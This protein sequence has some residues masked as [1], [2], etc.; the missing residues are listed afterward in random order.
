MNAEIISIGTE[1]LLGHVVD[2]NSSFLSCKLS[3]LGIDVYHHTTVGDNPAR[4]VE[5]IRKALGRADIVLMTG[6]LGPTVDDVTV[7][8]V[9]NLFGKS[10]VRPICNK[11]GSAPGIVAEYDNKVIVCLP[12]PPREAIPM[13]ENDIKPYI[14]KRFQS[15]GV[16]KSRVI[17]L[18][19]LG[20]SKVDVR[21]RSLLNLKPPTTVGIYAKLGEVD[22]KIMSK[23]KSEKEASK[24]IAG[25]EKKIR[26]KFKD[27]IFGYD[28]ETLEGVV[29]E[30]LA[31]KKKTLAIAESCTGGLISNRITDVS[32]SSR[33]F[34]TGMVTYS[35]ESKENFLGVSGDLIKRYGAVS[36]EVALE[37]AKGIKHFACTDIGLAVTGIAGPGGGSK[38]KPVGLVYIAL[39]T[40][41]KNIVKV[42]HFSGSR[43]DIKWKTSQTALEMIRRAIR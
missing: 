28:D 18:T 25:I 29:G 12:G 22:L 37:M 38:K 17:K 10:L 42:Y 15:E 21:V 32:G 11:V 40:D 24:A 41:K 33:Y 14:R 43:A 36:K 5:A 6:G 27:Y 16:I 30:I 35:N 7:E 13:F 20:E 34:K 1:L 4:L 8:A 26:S 3:E 9:I 19:G 31:K 2:T 23:A 39:V